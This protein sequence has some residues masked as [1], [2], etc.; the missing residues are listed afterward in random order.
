MIR[1][2]IQRKY[3]VHDI[4]QRGLEIKMLLV[5]LYPSLELLSLAIAFQPAN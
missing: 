1:V 4:Y 5:L 3:V 2:I